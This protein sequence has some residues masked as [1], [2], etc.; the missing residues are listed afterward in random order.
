MADWVSHR[1]SLYRVAQEPGLLSFVTPAWNTDVAYLRVLADSVLGQRGGTKFEWLI[2]DN[3]SRAPETIEFLGRL[4]RFPCVR[5][6]RVEE[7]LGIIGGMRFC[8]KHA[9]GRYILPLDH[10]DYLYPDCV[11]ILTWHIKTNNYPLLVYSDEDKLIGETYAYAYFK[12]AWD[13]VLF[14][15]SCYIAHLCAIDRTLALELG[16]Y[17]DNG[18]EGSPDWDTFMRFLLAGHTPVHVPEVIYSWRMHQGSTAFN[19]HSKSYIHDSQKRVLNKFLSAQTRADLYRLDM[20]PLFDGRPDWWIRRRHVEPRPLVTVVL[21][22]GA[23]KASAN[24]NL[25]AYPAHR[26][27]SLPVEDGIVALKEVAAEAA[28]RGGLVHLMCEK[29]ELEGSEWPWE[30]LTWMELVPDT[31]MVGGRIYDS[32]Q[33]ITAAGYYLGYGAGCGCPDRGR[34]LNDPGYFGQMWKQRSV[35]AVS[36]Q[37]AVVEGAFLN[38]FLETHSNLPVSLFYLGE[39][40]GAYARKRGRRVV[41]S[42]FLSGRSEENWATRVTAREKAAFL[43]ENEEV[44]PETAVL[45]PRLSLAPDS[46]YLPA[47]DALRRSHVERL[48]AGP[49]AAE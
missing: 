48:M 46:R 34:H 24:V 10:D 4:A 2:L 21:R 11:Q 29:L 36:C 9:Q 7:N 12:P 17:T 44:I 32:D 31:V 25:T 35:S 47:S 20:S 42:P 28:G 14:L 33:V 30:C 1:R 39:W 49:L 23:N 8:L 45:S 26:L 6:H 13:P 18:V 37:H 41:Y 5:L 38:E 15:N 3:G 43:A 22:D 27:V 19:T 16:A 40:L